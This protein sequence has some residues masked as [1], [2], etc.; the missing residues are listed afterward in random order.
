MTPINELINGQIVLAGE[1]MVELV[2]VKIICYV[3][4]LRPVGAS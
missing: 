1:T 2:K 4:G 3:I